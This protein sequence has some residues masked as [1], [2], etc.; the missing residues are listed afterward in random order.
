MF[1]WLFD[2]ERRRVSSIDASIEAKY[3]R[4]SFVRRPFSQ[5]TDDGVTLK[6]FFLEELLGDRSPREIPRE[7][8]PVIS[9]QTAGSAS[10]KKTVPKS[11]MLDTIP[12]VIRN[13]LNLL[14]LMKYRLTHLF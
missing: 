7:F 5:S 2:T 4:L 6:D 13:V 8:R 12:K 10:W 14:H 3:R 9:N 1:D 11:T